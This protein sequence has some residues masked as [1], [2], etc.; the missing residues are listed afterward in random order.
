MYLRAAKLVFITCKVTAL[1]P[2]RKTRRNAK[3]C[4][5]VMVEYFIKTMNEEGGRTY[6]YVC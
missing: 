4:R 2:T 1:N 5:P 6:I 3:P